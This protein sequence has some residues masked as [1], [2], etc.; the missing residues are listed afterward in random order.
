MLGEEHSGRGTSEYN[1]PGVGLSDGNRTS[2]RKAR[3]SE[4]R[5]VGGPVATHH[6]GLGDMVGTLDFILNCWGI[7][8]GSEQETDTT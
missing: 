1:G 2:L 8:E 7:R 4:D 6:Q 3:G 5:R